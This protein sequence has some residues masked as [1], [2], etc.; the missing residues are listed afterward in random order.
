[1]HRVGMTMLFLI[2]GGVSFVLGLQSVNDVEPIEV[3]GAQPAQTT[4]LSIVLQYTPVAGGAAIPLVVT[5]VMNSSQTALVNL[6]EIHTGL[7]QPALSSD[8]C[9]TTNTTGRCIISNVPVGGNPESQY[10]ILIDTVFLEFLTGVPLDST[11]AFVRFDQTQCG[12]HTSFS[13]TPGGAT[14]FCIGQSGGSYASQYIVTIT[15]SERNACTGSIPPA[16]FCDSD[17]RKIVQFTCNPSTT[18]STRPWEPVTSPCAGPVQCPDGNMVDGRCGRIGTSMASCSTAFACAQN[19]LCTIQNFGTHL[20]YVAGR[21]TIIIRGQHFGVAG[22]TVSFPVEGGG[23]ELVQVF[24]GADWIDTEIRVRVPLTAIS[25]SLEIHP[26]THGFFTGPN[27]AL[28]P[29]VCVSPSASIQAFS[30]QFSILS[31]N[32]TTPTGVQLVSPGFSTLFTLIAQHNDTVD[33]FDSIV[34]ELV[35]GA[36]P[37]PANIPLQRTVITQVE[38]PV[39]ILGS[40]AVKEATLS[41]SVPVPANATQFPGPFTFIVTLTDDAGGIERA[42]ILDSGNSAMS[43]D[44]NFDGILTI[45]DAAVAFRISLGTVAQ[46]TAHRDRDTNGD[47][48]ITNADALY[49]LHSLTR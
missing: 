3:T 5:Q 15:L 10:D 16:A 25:G 34:V 2:A 18:S 36:F 40:T 22:G 23:R 6:Q 12:S 27:N 14:G 49:V 17:P 42:T 29:A 13:V 28:I 41:C 26:N 30:D 19:Q 9:R 33:R 43:G 39:T 35:E 45:E 4:S 46:T 37:D 44:F 7:I 21:D 20:S 38:C 31:L 8:R 1:M 48:V 24:P 11:N 32:A 47:F